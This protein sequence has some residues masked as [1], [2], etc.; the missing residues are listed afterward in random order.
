MLPTT[1]GSEVGGTG[2]VASFPSP[3]PCSPAP[4]GPVGDQFPTQRPPPADAGPRTHPCGTGRVFRLHPRLSACRPGS[5]VS[6]K[7]GGVRPVGG[8]QPEPRNPSH[9]A[10]SG[11][12]AL[13]CSRVPAEPCWLSTC[14][15]TCPWGGLAV[16]G[17]AHMV[18]VAPDSGGR[19]SPRHL[20][21]EREAPARPAGG[22]RVSTLFLGRPPELLT[23][24]HL[25]PPGPPGSADQAAGAT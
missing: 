11:A 4:H 7:A 18:P 13:L 15:R 25:L 16:P 22:S 2:G 10:P 14:W 1:L 23:P 6:G 5:H 9:A 3:S 20:A 19:R 24:A 8:A 21:P 17:S 12:G